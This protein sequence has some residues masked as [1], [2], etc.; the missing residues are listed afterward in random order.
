[1]NYPNI[2]LP[3]NFDTTIIDGVLQDTLKT[4]NDEFEGQ[5]IDYCGHA[6]SW[7]ECLSGFVKDGQLILLLQF[8]ICENT[9][10]YKVDVTI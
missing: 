3:E 1:M 9:Y 6:R 4:L 5:P 7:E 10:G 2:I 8:N